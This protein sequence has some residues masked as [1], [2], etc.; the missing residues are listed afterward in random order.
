MDYNTGTYKIY[1]QKKWKCEHC[2]KDIYKIYHFARV[3]EYGQLLKR[4]DG[5]NYYKKEYKRY[6]FKCARNLKNLNNKE[7]ELLNNNKYY[8]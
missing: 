3:K 5:E 6:H 2:K 1:A 8:N 7:K 4:R